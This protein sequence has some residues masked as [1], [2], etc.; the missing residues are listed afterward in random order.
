MNYGTRNNKIFKGKDICPFCQ[1]METCYHIHICDDC[2]A[3]DSRNKDWSKLQQSLNHY[4]LPNIF[5]TYIGNYLRQWTVG[6]RQ[7]QPVRRYTNPTPTCE[8]TRKMSTAC[9]VQSDIGWNNFLQGRIAKDFQVAMAFHLHH[10]KSTLSPKQCTSVLIKGLW[11]YYND[12]WGTRCDL[13]HLDSDEEATIHQKLKLQEN[14]EAIWNQYD[15]NLP[16]T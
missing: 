12:V 15:P 8:F 4:K 11:Q 6:Q 9:K 14:I 1:K 16:L 10:N 5:W 2:R 7:N 3:T 13:F